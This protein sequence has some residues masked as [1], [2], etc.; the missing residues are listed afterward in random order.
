MKFK[1]GETKPLII[2]AEAEM[3][4]AE[5]SKNCKIPYV[6][7]KP[8]AREQ[9]TKLFSQRWYHLNE[10]HCLSCGWISETMRTRYL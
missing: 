3:K 5:E 8:L 9:E 2:K 1:L 10:W 7:K 6:V 4:H